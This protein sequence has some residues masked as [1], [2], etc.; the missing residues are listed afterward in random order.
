MDM[1][2]PHR[3]E[4][5]RGDDPKRR[6]IV[7]TAIATGLAGLA[8]AGFAFTDPAAGLAAKVF[9]PLFL[10]CAGLLMG[11]RERQAAAESGDAPAEGHVRRLEGVVRAGLVILIG[12]A[13]ATVFDTSSDGI[14]RVIGIPLAVVLV[15]AARQV[16][17]L[18]ERRTA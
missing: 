13:V 18:L 8:V 3:P 11:L 4:R 5:P 17:T 10:L 14:L 7:G 2:E 9:V 12:V 15:L 16:V 1:D 6:R